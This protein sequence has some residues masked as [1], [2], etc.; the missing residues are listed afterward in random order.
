[1]T[2]TRKVRL[3]PTGDCFCGCGGEAEIGRWF[4][5]GHDITAAAALRALEGMKLPRRL[6]SLGF[7]PERSVVQAAVG[8]AG[9]VRCAGCAY[10]GTPANLASHTRAGS[11]A[12]AGERQLSGPPD[13][14][15]GRTTRRGRRSRCICASGC[16]YSRTSW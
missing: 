7:G 10:V 13:R 4:V 5:R 14:S 3:V 16:G 15:P 6:V 8:E 1:M 2:D 12:T 9:W 11:C